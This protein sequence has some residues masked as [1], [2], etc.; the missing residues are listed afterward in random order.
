MRRS[1]R[2]PE[3][4]VSSSRA[5]RSTRAVRDCSIVVNPLQLLIRRATRSK[6]VGDNPRDRRSRAAAGLTRVAADEV[7]TPIVGVRPRLQ[8]GSIIVCAGISSQLNSIR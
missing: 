6:S 1:A 8:R 5:R 2:L 7:R 3:I 4:W